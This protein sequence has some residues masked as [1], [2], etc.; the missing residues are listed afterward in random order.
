MSLAG[1]A[2][3]L[4]HQVF[5]AARLTGDW[6]GL[7]DF[8]VQRGNWQ[9]SP[10]VSAL[11]GAAGL[12]IEFIGCWFGGAAGRAVMVLGALSVMV[13]FALTGHTTHPSVSPIV[14]FLLASHVTIVGYWI[15]SV[16]ALL[17]LTRVATAPLVKSVSTAFSMS[18]VW[19]VPAILPIGIGIA[20]GLLPNLAALRSVYGLLLA[21]KVSGFAVLLGLAAINRWRLVPALE[22]QPQIGIRRYR[23][24]LH[25]EYLLLIG[26]L[27]VTAFMTSFF[28]WH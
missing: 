4:T 10:G 9:R 23:G 12:A 16:V 28:S 5:E 2:L 22:Q 17:R 19:L 20:I 14:R 13:S 18:A 26:V 25:A 11:V 6:S 15:G 24:T 1:F 7:L 27:S 3:V 21:C 8:D